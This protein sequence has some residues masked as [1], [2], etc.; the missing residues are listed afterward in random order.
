[1]S[2]NLNTPQ[3][4]NY[5][6][7]NAVPSGS[8]IEPDTSVKYTPQ[9]LTE[10]QQAQARQ[11]I[12]VEASEQVQAN[13]NEN[14]TTSPA[15][16]QNKP[17]IPAA[18]VQADWN[19]SDN[20]AP[21]YI[22]NKPNIS[23]PDFSV[24]EDMPGSLI[25]YSSAHGQPVQFNNGSYQ[26]LLADTIITDGVYHYYPNKIRDFGIA[27]KTVIHIPI[28]PTDRT[29]T[30]YFRFYPNG[31]FD[32]LWLH[33][34][35]DWYGNSNNVILAEPFYQDLDCKDANIVINSYGAQQWNMYKIN[36]TTS[37]N[38]QKFTVWT[39]T[40]TLWKEIWTGTGDVVMFDTDTYFKNEAEAPASL[41]GFTLYLPKNRYSSIVA[42]LKSDF[43]D[44][45]VEN[46]ILP[47]VQT[48]DFIYSEGFK[49]KMFTLPTA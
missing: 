7:L 11:N 18:Q 48:Y 39:V 49:Y 27:G 9:T 21:D 47:Q 16:I 32:Y 19:Q 15:Y 25:F 43:G 34:S 1:M 41:I 17:T 13:W 10:E 20:T 36:H 26:K 14:D 40:N 28:D 35:Y 6:G 2:L 31:T 38:I 44:S 42:Q 45:E 33:T 46:Y 30:G 3:V 23:G 12:G 37:Q 22:K 5:T 8:T 24:V 29:H 4:R